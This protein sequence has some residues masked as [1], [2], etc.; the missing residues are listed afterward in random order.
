[1]AFPPQILLAHLLLHIRMGCN[2][3][4]NITPSMHVLYKLIILRGILTVSLKY[5]AMPMQCVQHCRVH[6]D[7]HHSY[8]YFTADQ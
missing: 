1:M 5:A 7:Q 2:R 4:D 8:L 3:T 6:A